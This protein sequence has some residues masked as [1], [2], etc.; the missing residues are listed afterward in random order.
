MRAYKFL[1][2]KFG[3]KSLHEKRLK[4]SVL[5]DLNDPFELLPYQMT[6]RNK[7]A[8]LNATRR[9]VASNR[10]LLC[11]SATWKDPVLWAHYANKHKGLCLA[12][13]VP[14]EACKAVTYE[15]RRLNLPA[16]PSLPD[17]EAL[18]FTKYVNWQYEQEL[19]IW[20]ALNTCENGLY[21]ADFG[22]TLKLEKI[23]AGARCLLSE[24][25]IAAE[26]ESLAEKVTI[27]KARA[28]FKEFEIVKDQ[29]GFISQ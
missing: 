9:Q 10:G 8:A 28:G 18:I 1:D 3:I 23:I 19:R 12:F 16:K 5:D 29:R 22:P 7:R 11:F 27:I 25:E 26:I 21:F 20:V 24:R 13:D 6:D 14:E 4:I 2:E 17:A 15:R